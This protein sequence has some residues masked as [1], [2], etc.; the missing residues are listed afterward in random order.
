MR[1]GNPSFCRGR[2]AGIFGLLGLANV[3]AWGWALHVYGDRPVLLGTALLAWSLG[4][5]HAV[6]ADHIA[7]ID[8]TTRGG[9][10]PYLL[11]VCSC[12]GPTELFRCEPDGARE[13][14]I[15]RCAS[16]GSDHREFAP[17]RA[18][19]AQ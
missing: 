1:I 12:G 18:R 10:D 16:C 11:P 7:A 9:F 4:L 14:R 3:A 6:D 17:P 13:A 8:N 2:M 19:D 5:R 15:C